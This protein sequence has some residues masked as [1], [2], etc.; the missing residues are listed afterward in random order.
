MSL[1]KMIQN[2]ETV[3]WLG[4]NLE[5]NEIESIKQLSLISARIE[6]KR[7]EMG[8]GQKEFAQ[9]MGVTQGMVSK[10]ESGEYNF[11]ITTLHDICKRL[12]LIFEP[13]IRENE[14]RE[15]EGFELIKVTSNSSIK[16]NQRWKLLNNVPYSEGIA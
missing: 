13:V 5:K 4:D 2:A 7:K 1:Q 6:L 11:T 15:E 12:N 8:M 14:Y 3:D 9:Y 10:W 16:K